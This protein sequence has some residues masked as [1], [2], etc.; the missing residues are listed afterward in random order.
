MPLKKIKFNSINVCI[1]TTFIVSLIFLYFFV[2]FFSYGFE[3]TDETYYI[4][5][6]SDP[7]EYNVTATQFGFVYH[8]LYKI[9]YGN[10][11]S[12]RL[13]NFGFILLIYMV[14]SY[15]FFDYF[16]LV[17]SKIPKKYLLLLSW[18]LAITSLS[19][20]SLWLPTPN[21]NLLNYQALALALIGVILVCRAKNSNQRQGKISYFGGWIVIG[22]SGFL[23]FMA[24][25]HTGTGLAFLILIWAWVTSNFKIKGLAISIFVAFSL[26]F[27]T[28]ILL[29]GSINS[30]IQRYVIF[31]EGS[32]IAASH[33]NSLIF[34]FN[35]QIFYN[36]LTWPLII[37]FAIL[38]FMGGLI[39][40]FSEE[41]FEK[42]YFIAIYLY[43]GIC[44]AIISF[45]NAYM[46]IINNSGH[47]LWAPVFGAILVH[48]KRNSQII[49]W[50]ARSRLGWS[51]F[52]LV[53][54]YLYGLG[55]NNQ[56]TF[57][58]S[59][60]SFYIL[61]ALIL[62]FNNNKTT[63]NLSNLVVGL[64]ISSFYVTVII[65]I[66]AWARPYRQ[67][68]PLWTFKTQL[69]VP[70]GGAKLKFPSLMASFMTQWYE[71][72]KNSSYL[73]GTPII[74]LTGRSPG[75]IFILGGF[76]P[77]NPWITFGYSGSEEAAKDSLLRLSCEE[78]AAA[79][80]I[81][82]Y[83]G[84]AV[85]NPAIL[86]EAGVDYESDY[87]LRGVINFPMGFKTIQ[88]RPLA[89]LSPKS[90]DQRCLLCVQRRDKIN[91]K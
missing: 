79:W 38:T 7:W 14:V 22:L 58:T 67:I 41:N 39:S 2:K 43:I 13:V 77:K 61:L 65:M 59:L 50:P 52:I 70:M 69:E 17:S 33:N 45:I 56:I 24:R 47:L 66:I 54:V 29:D 12:L 26:V 81:T 53:L 8:I 64:I 46:P 85:F 60:A 91:Y 44:L 36:S 63:L 72:A 18:I 4:N 37:T 35:V 3:F 90:I 16:N 57:T 5:L 74:D 68:A 27:L 82:D 30:F 31:Y 88:Y 23:A 48:I 9:F 76:L 75:A 83:H 55:S 71:L 40:Y 6:I 62:L 42:N 86:L 10:I 28:A 21:Y 78:L 51:G 34:N 1:T 80:V 19:I 73:P 11:A 89:L 84:N 32:K 20:Y 49:I 25:P 87:T 15:L